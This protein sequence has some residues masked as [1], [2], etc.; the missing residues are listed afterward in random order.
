MPSSARSFV[1]EHE[2][3]P[4]PENLIGPKNFK[5]LCAVGV[6]K[7]RDLGFMQLDWTGFDL[8]TWSGFEKT[9]EKHRSL[10]QI[11]SS[12][13]TPADFDISKFDLAQNT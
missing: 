9:F 1:P 11:Y 3:F 13:Y 5:L 4:I 8:A 10:T 12:N 7:L 2:K 6:T